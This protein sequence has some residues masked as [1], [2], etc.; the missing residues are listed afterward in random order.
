MEKLS[1]LLIVT[2]VVMVFSG[3]TAEQFSRNVYEGVRVHNESLKSTPLETSK[4]E[5]MSYDKYEK[6]RRNS[7]VGQSK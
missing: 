3:C 6:E 4:S 1:I 7:S 2:F 5:P